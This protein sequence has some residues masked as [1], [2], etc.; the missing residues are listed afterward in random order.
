MTVELGGVDK[1]V[2]AF[3]QDLG[4][5]LGFFLIRPLRFVDK[6]CGVS[7]C[8][9]AGDVG[10]GLLPDQCRDVLFFQ[11]FVLRLVDGNQLIDQG[12]LR[13]DQVAGRFRLAVGDIDLSA[14]LRQ[15]ELKL[16][17][18]L[19][20][21][22]DR[23][24]VIELGKSLTGHHVVKTPDEEVLQARLYNGGNRGQLAGNDAIASDP[25]PVGG[26]STNDCCTDGE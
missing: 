3:L 26:Q 14:R 5:E 15:L 2:D 23:R 4:V 12:S 6:L 17:Q 19:R 22:F 24:L 21:G 25:R 18:L 1:A 11:Q 16:V 20:R 7:L 9:G 13:I 10:F 8:V